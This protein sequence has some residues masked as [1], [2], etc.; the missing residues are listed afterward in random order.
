V[1]LPLSHDY[2]PMEA[3][4]VTEIPV[5]DDWQYEPKWDGFRCIAFRDGKQVDLMSKAGKPLG[6]YFPELVHALSAL[7]GPK[8]VLDGE[9]VIAEGD[10]LAFDELQQ[11]IH[12][13]ASRIAK[14]STE[15]PA[16][17]IVFDMLVN[18]SGKSIAAQPLSVRRAAL[19]SFAAKQL[20]WQSTV[21][22]SPATSDLRTVQGWFATVG[23]GL[24]GIIAKRMDTGYRS[25]T[26]DGM[27]KLK[28]KWT[29][30]CVVGGFR[31]ATSRRQVGSLL[32]G[33]YN[34]DGKLDHVGFVSGIRKED[35]PA[36]TK[37]LE[38]LVKPPGFTGNAPGGPSRWST[39][40]SSEWQPL[41]PRLVVEVEYDHFT[42]GRFRHGTNLVRWRP[43]KSPRQCT[44][45]QFP[46]VNESALKLLD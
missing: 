31:Y 5:G 41:A 40:R 16:S 7:A 37:R 22:L 35:R 46:A 24:D 9:I 26:R 15:H 42:E 21:R 1:A 6:R 45:D 33:L 43:D 27:Q 4:P 10:R 28:H 18:A 23:S 38:K 20:R 39:E 2:P 17:Y 19:E 3:R 29:A 14:L 30:D 44:I 25:G 11:R 8:F 13:A 32:L 36:L 12:P 34:R